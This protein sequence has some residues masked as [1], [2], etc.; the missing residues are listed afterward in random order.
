MELHHF[1]LKNLA[2]ARDRLRYYFLDP[3][4]R[5]HSLVGSPK[6][7]RQK[8]AIQIRFLKE[9]GLRP[10]H[11]LLDVG[12]GTLRGGLPVIEYLE[13]GHY[14]GLDRSEQALAEGRREVEE[15]G[16]AEK[17]PVLRGSDDFDRCDL[18]R[19]FDF[20]W[21][22]SVLIHLEDPVLSAC[23]ALVR[24]HLDEGGVFFANVNL[25]DRPRDFLGG[26][27]G[28]PVVRRT[29]GFYQEMAAGHGLR[30]ESLGR[31]DSLGLAV[32]KRA[33]DRQTMLKFTPS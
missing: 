25:A 6:L 23:L 15:A 18:G 21:A 9:A 11:Y 26:W 22:F 27:R 1:L 2:A 20:V 12:C 33:H 16:L 24:R 3:Q 19:R 5:R 10:E 29:Q 7:W 4:E 14:Y 31:L 28:H 8:R 30:V 32:G 13:K 17:A